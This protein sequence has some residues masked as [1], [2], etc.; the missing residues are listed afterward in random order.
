M[1]F[2][3]ISPYLADYL[4]LEYYSSVWKNFPNQD[5][6]VTVKFLLYSK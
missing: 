3:K 1:I 6:T 5:K 2:G 4:Y